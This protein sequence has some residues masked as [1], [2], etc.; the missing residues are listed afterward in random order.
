[1]LGSA[2]NFVTHDGS[3]Y[4]YHHD[5]KMPP[6]LLGLPIGFGWEVPAL[7]TTTHCFG[8][9]QKALALFESMKQASGL[10]DIWNGLRRLRE[11]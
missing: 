9:L 8:G 10:R 6:V 5:S 11:S 3:E 7:C 1:M 2:A 4:D